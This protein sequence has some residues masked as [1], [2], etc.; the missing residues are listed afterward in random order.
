MKNKF[1]RR[2]LA[3]SLCASLIGSAAVN[4]PLI[5][6]ESGITASA[7][8]ITDDFTYKSDYNGGIVITKYTGTDENVVIP[9]EIEG[10]PVTEIGSS[11]FENNKNMKSVSIP[12]SVK[13]IGFDS[14]SGCTGLTSITIPGS[15]T[16]IDTFAFF[17]CKG[18]KSVTIPDSVTEI[19]EQAFA[20]CE[21]LAD[22]NGFS[23]VKGVLY[24]Y[25]GKESSVDRKSVV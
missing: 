14:F 4:I 9:K 24:D 20:S 17:G 19:K 13:T 12:D 1:L 2:L 21:G 5:V 15:V 23:V 11:A 22:S 10:K 7:A 6:P 8:S 3:V 16:T 25:F 18:L